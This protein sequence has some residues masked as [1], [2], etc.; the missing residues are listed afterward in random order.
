LDDIACNAACCAERS[1]TCSRARNSC[2]SAG[3]QASSGCRESNRGTGHS[4][5]CGST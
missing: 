1:P 2:R 5:T 3:R 4:A